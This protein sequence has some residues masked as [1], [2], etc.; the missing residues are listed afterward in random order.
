[1]L[2]HEFFFPTNMLTSHPFKKTVQ[3]KFGKWKYGK[4]IQRGEMDGLPVWT[5]MTILRFFKKYTK[6]ATSK[7]V[8]MLFS[9]FTGHGTKILSSKKLSSLDCFAPI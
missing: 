7:F 6:C 2:L 9:C 1:M 5:E 4:M 3:K 8:G